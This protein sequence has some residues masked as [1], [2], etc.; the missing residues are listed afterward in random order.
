MIP[1]RALCAAVSAAKARGIKSENSQ[2]FV[3]FFCSWLDDRQQGTNKR[4]GDARFARN[5]RLHGGHSESCLEENTP[6]VIKWW[7]HD[8]CLADV[9]RFVCTS[10]NFV[11]RSFNV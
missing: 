4:V 1:L 10:N 7:P 3:D 6:S 5:H 11:A 8:E 9:R 2:G